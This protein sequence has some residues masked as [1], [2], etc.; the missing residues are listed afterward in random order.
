LKNATDNIV[1]TLK[2]FDDYEDSATK[3]LAG[4]FID[5]VVIPESNKIIGILLAI[6]KKQE[7]IA[8]N[9]TNTLVQSTGR[10]RTITIVLG[11]AIIGIGFLSAY[12]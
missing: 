2:S 10:L 3:L 1:N 7:Q 12:L 4:D 6:K 5:Q 9:S 11:L 8:D